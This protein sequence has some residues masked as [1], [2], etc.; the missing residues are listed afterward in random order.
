MNRKRFATE[1]QI[2]W[3]LDKKATKLAALGKGIEAF[4]VATAMKH[5]VKPTPEECGQF[6]VRGY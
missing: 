5:L 1:K 2:W 3:E 4:E 6:Y